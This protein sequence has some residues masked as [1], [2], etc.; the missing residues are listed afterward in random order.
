LTERERT[1]L[2]YL[3]TLLNTADIAA[4]LFITTN[5]VKSHQQS[6][7]RKLAVNTR[8]EAVDRAR[9]LKLL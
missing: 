2:K 8:R 6:L 5:T 4:D 7:Y 1:V 9:T 3:P